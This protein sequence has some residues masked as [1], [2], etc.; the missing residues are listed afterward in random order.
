MCKPLAVY[1]VGRFYYELADVKIARSVEP[2]REAGLVLHSGWGTEAVEADIL[3]GRKQDPRLLDLMAR[4]AKAA[5]P[6][7][8]IGIP[9]YYHSQDNWSRNVVPMGRG[10]R[11]MWQGIVK[12]LCPDQG[13]R[14]A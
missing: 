5:F 6:R 10:T 8:A 11:S 13:S 12:S 4:C 1:S 2:L 7:L 14:D 9:M 3:G